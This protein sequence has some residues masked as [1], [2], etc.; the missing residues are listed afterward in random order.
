MLLSAICCSAVWF[1][2]SN[3]FVEAVEIIWSQIQD[4]GGRRF[5]KTKHLNEKL[6]KNKA[7]IADRLKRLDQQVETTDKL[8]KHTGRNVTIYRCG[9][10]AKTGEAS[11]GRRRS[12]KRHIG[13]PIL[14]N[15]T[16]TN[17]NKSR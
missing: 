14:K 7:C 6:L 1:I 13:T 12:Y 3:I 5:K 17:K 11:E 8:T 10:M 2:S 15:K 9:K 4:T 16:R